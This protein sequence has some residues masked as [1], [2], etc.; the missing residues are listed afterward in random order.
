MRAKSTEYFKSKKKIS[1]FPYRLWIF[2][3][4]LYLPCCNKQTHSFIWTM[5]ALIIYIINYCGFSFV[6]GKQNVKN[7]LTHR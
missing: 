4:G 3:L 1:I 6:F 7:P 5:K 2:T